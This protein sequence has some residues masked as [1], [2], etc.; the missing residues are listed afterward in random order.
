MQ[1]VYLSVATYNE[2][3]KTN[4]HAELRE[5]LTLKMSR[6]KIFEFKCGKAIGWGSFSLGDFYASFSM[7]PEASITIRQKTN[8]ETKVGK[9]EG[10]GNI[11]LPLK[12]EVGLE[13]KVDGIFNYNISVPIV[14]GGK[15]EY[16]FKGDMKT[17][18]V[19][20][21][22]DRTNLNITA[23]IDIG[24]FGEK[25]IKLT[26]VLFDTTWKSDPKKINLLNLIK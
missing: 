5:D 17:L 20:F 19:Y 7:T 6:L 11:T 14:A 1:Q 8:I 18:G 21:Y 16:P 22:M 13:K 4:R 9:I 2:E 25:N 3:I 10:F 24:I 26:Y 15:G 12:T 23:N